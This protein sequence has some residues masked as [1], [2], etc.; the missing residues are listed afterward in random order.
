[1][2]DSLDLTGKV[3]LVTGGNG[4]IGLGMAEGLAAAGASIVIWGRNAARNASATEAI[5]SHGR[6]VLALTVDVGDEQQV[7]DAFVET[8]AAHGQVDAVFAN[9][10]IGAGGTPF[11]DMTTDEWR[12]I[13]R[14][15]MDGVFWTFREAVGHMKSRGSGSLV[16]TSSVSADF[17]FP[18]GEHYS[19]TKAGVRAL[20]QGIAVEYGRYGI[21]ANAV[22]PGWVVTGMTDGFIE[23]D[24]FEANVKPRIP[25]GRW[26]RPSD[27]AGIAV[28]LASDA[29]T[30][31][32][33][34]TITIDGGYLRK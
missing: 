2:S 20:I 14:I 21:R 17:G 23:E 25:I 6:P 24:R 30:W 33:G 18:R 13:F 29:S 32:T 1:M 31:H 15:N 22:S 27:F 5:A 26:G 34:D 9:A 16:V 4:G 10:G 19:A 12:A 8:V 11:A 7:V 28:Y 3:A